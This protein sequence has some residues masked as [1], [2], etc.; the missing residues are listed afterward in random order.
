MIK[1]SWNSSVHHNPRP[2]VTLAHHMSSF[3]GWARVWL[4]N[5]HKLGS[6]LSNITLQWLH[7]MLHEVMHLCF[8]RAHL[9][10]NV[11]PCHTTH[12]LVRIHT[13]YFS[14]ALLSLGEAGAWGSG[15]AAGGAG[16]LFAFSS[17]S[18][19]SSS[20]IIIAMVIAAATPG[21]KC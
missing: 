1:P 7:N 12:A 16:G 21:H 8:Q 13:N 6:V 19:M 11:P 3:S 9:V 20:V 4:Q 14:K 15:G 17:M 18:S 10:C 5:A 2:A